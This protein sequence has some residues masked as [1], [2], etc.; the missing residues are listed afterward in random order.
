MS[1]SPAR[2]GAFRFWTRPA[3]QAGLI[4]FVVGLTAQWWS[5]ATRLAFAFWDAQA[6]LDIAR[7]VVDSTTPGLQML[8]TGWL[9]VPHLLML[10]FVRVDAWW[11]NGVAG[12]I[13]GLAAFIAAAAAIHDLLS[14]HVAD[15]RFAWLGTSLVLLNPSLFYLQT[16]AMTA[17]VLLAFLTL[18]VA[19]IDRWRES[20][21]P[22]TLLFAGIFAALAVGSRYDGW[23][24]V[25][26]AT[27]AVAWLGR[28]TRSGWFRSAVRFGLPSALVVAAWLWFNWHYYGDPL[29]FQRGVWSAQSQQAA[30]AAQGLLPTKGHPLLSTWYYAGAMALT[31]GL[32][33]C[34]AALLLLPFAL[35]DRGRAVATVLLLTALPFNILALWAGQTVIALPWT[36][37]W[38]QNVRYGLMVLPGLAACVTFGLDRLGGRGAGWRKGTVLAGLALVLAQGALFGWH[39]PAQAGAL[40]EGLA[41]RDFDR[42]QQHASDWLAAHYDGGRVLVDGAVNL[43]PRT[44]IPIRDRIYDWTWQLGPAALAAP[45]REVDWVV[46]DR[47]HDD[48]PVSRAIADRAPFEKRFDRVFD[49]AGL[50][51]WRRR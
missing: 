19:A 40:R 21:V 42:R 17:P 38:V 8:G 36:T 44:R 1:T 5:Q 24:F 48:G 4:A 12:G 29:E 49:D 20:H 30:L 22:R 27:P 23:F 3:V 31:D 39:W 16:T 41:V 10:P 28:A 15:R 18:A 47:R 35:R 37:G 45:E 2:V 14:R 9:P 13:V 43:S 34:V 25:A 51:I 26:I 46:V 11:W 50:E 33:A 6:H 7:R 32:L